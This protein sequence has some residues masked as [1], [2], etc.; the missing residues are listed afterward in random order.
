MLDTDP[1]ALP[2]D[3]DPDDLDPAPEDLEELEKAE[4]ADDDLDGFGEP[5]TPGQDDTD[6]FGRLRH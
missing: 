6:Q 5:P 4:D 2:D 3:L 1:E